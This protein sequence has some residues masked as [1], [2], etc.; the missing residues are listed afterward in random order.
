M[1]YPLLSAAVALTSEGINRARIRASAG[2]YVLGMLQIGGA[3]TPRHVGRSDEDLR[4]ELIKQ[5][6]KESHFVFAHLKSAARAY[7]AE[8]ELFHHLSSQEQDH[9]PRRPGGTN[10]RCPHCGR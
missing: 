7:V 8:C 1:T 9:H 5:I 2:V 3:I 4:A 6:G 10:Y